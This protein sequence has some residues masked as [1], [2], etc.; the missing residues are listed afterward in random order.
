MSEV[1]LSLRF[2][3]GFN[4]SGLLNTNYARIAL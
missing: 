2:E 1:N 3:P 4:T